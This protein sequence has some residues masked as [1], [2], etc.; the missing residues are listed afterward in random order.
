MPCAACHCNGSAPLRPTVQGTR[1]HSTTPFRKR[2]AVKISTGITASILN[3]AIRQGSKSRLTHPD[4]N[5]TTRADYIFGPQLAVTSWLGRV[6]YAL[7][8]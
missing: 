3:V 1:L 6:V 4:G 2:P 8:L 7:C 5:E